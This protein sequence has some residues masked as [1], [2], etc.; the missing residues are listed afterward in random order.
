ML[1]IGQVHDRASPAMGVT[2]YLIG[3]TFDGCCTSCVTTSVQCFA[4]T[5]IAVQPVADGK[6]VLEWVLA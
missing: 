2:P 5:W 3:R 6:L 4:L 1:P